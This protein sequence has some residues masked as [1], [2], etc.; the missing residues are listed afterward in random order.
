MRSTPE[1]VV[2]LIRHGAS[3]FNLEGRCQGCSDEP[4]LSELGREEARLSG[5]RLRRA[6]IEA[7]ISSPLRRAA[8]TALTLMYMLGP[9]VADIGFE[10]DARLREIELPQWEGLCFAE[11]RRRFPDQF[12][13]W[14]LDP[15]QMS[16]PAPSGISQFPV[17]SLY[18]RVRQV[19]RDLLADYAGRS[20]LL[21]THGGTGR[22]LITTA[23]GLGEK[24]FHS[25]QQSH[26][27][28]S[29]L[30]FSGPGHGAQLELLND[31]AHLGDRLPKLKEG[32]AGIR[33]LLIPAMSSDPAGL[34]QI[35]SVLAPLAIDSVSAAGAAA[36]DAVSAIFQGRA[37]E[38]IE[39]VSE[40]ALGR[41]LRHAMENESERDNE[42]RHM[43]FVAS[44]DC[45]QR[46][47]RERF[48]LAS[49]AMN[50][51]ITAVHCPGHGLPPVLQAINAFEPEFGLV[52]V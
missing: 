47:L 11:I 21:V 50:S 41:R 34:R 29:R 14:R 49:S 12:L 46:V 43:A 51:G 45:L 8:D 18:R 24:H 39:H 37:Q 3:T 1:T 19:W 30:R 13:T 10:T 35:S 52:G 5:L 6:G 17:L 32:R 25:L 16:M 4:K 40:E 48:G 42:L 9:E 44:P 2:W 36:R 31:T 22:A 28:I 15:G 27:G 26:C 7:V 23:L 38:S 33:L 20:I